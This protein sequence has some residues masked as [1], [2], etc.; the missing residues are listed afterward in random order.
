MAGTATGA[1]FF[2]PAGIGLVG[3]AMAL[4][5]GVM[6]A[7]AAAVVAGVLARRLPPRSL[8]RSAVVA[9]LFAVLAALA[10]GY[11]FV[12]QQAERR[13]QADLDAGTLQHP[14]LDPRCAARLS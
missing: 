11:G 9:L 8:R 14:G 12:T 13:A 5:F 6:G 2:V 3:S 10:V 1:R 7:L 4:G